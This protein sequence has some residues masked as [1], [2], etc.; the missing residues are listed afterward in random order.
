MMTSVPL[1]ILCFFYQAIDA[2]LRFR[3]C[4]PAVDK[5]SI[6]QNHNFDRFRFVL[7]YWQVNFLQAPPCSPGATLHFPIG[8]SNEHLLIL[9][10]ENYIELQIPLLI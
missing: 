10:I 5:L 2:L 1:S 9:Q 4:C 3:A 8:P 7:S 6:Y